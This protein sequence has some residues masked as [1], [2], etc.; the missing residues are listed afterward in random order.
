MTF[1]AR[2]PVRAGIRLGIG[3]KNCHATV[4][5]FMPKRVRPP[6]L[7]VE[8]AVASGVRIAHNFRFW[9]FFAYFAKKAPIFC[10]CEKKPSAK[11]ME[12]LV[13]VS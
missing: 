6:S 8:I 5:T 12:G 7:Y 10:F 13:T 9:I 1:L 11:K 2:T 4:F 3:Q